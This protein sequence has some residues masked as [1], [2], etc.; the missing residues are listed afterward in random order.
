MLLLCLVL[1][2]GSHH[3]LQ[4]KALP[5]TPPGRQNMCFIARAAEAYIHLACLAGQQE[6]LEL[7]STFQAELGFSIVPEGKIS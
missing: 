7:H 2:F 3:L 5:G 6:L 4:G 1:P